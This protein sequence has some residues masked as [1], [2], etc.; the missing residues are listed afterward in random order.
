MTILQAKRFAST[1]ESVV[2][3]LRDRSYLR[4]LKPYIPPEDV[5]QKLNGIFES[6]LGSNSAQLSNGRI[7]FKVLSA[8]FK[9]FKHGVP[10]SRLHEILTTG[11]KHTSQEP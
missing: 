10:N 8:C 1:I 7:K 11:I 2:K 5:E 6:Q 9:E 4:P 3:S